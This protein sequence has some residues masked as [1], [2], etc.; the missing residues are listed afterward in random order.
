MTINGREVKINR[1][2]EEA[3]PEARIWVN[4]RTV[5]RPIEDQGEEFGAERHAFFINGKRFSRSAV[6]KRM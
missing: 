2:I 3:G 1:E 5:T 4:G 6:L